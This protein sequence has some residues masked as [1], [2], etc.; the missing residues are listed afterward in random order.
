MASADEVTLWRG[1]PP[2]RPDPAR[3]VVDGYAAGDYPG[4]GVYLATARRIAEDFA[5][6]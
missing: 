2:G 3:E 4:D 5:A 6:C 1:V